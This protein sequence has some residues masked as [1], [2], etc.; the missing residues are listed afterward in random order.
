MKKVLLFDGLAKL[1]SLYLVNRIPTV[2]GLGGV[3]GFHFLALPAQS[4]TRFEPAI[5]TNSPN[6]SNEKFGELSK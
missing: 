2:V 5:K 3:G 1:R 6:A 4:Q